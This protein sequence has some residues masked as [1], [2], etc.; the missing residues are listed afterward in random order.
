MFMETTIPLVEALGG[1]TFTI[2]HL[3]DR[4]LVVKSK[5]GD[6]IT[7]GEIRVI[8][9]EGM[10][11][12]KR[13]FEKGNLIIQFNV[14]FPKPGQLSPKQIEQLEKL[15]P[16]R[17]PAPKITDSMEE[18]ELTKMTE[19]QRRESARRQARGGEAYDEDEDN[20][21]GQRVQCAQQ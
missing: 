10:P 7:P 15:L 1:F 16:G 3:D 14:E 19:Q 4:V 20:H 6:I 17:R 18:V 8:P 11:I 12:H 2:K 9:N 13:P 21:G 5:P